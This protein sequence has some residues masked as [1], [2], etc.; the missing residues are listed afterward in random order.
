MRDPKITY[1]QYTTEQLT[2]S[3]EEHTASLRS[4]EKVHTEFGIVAMVHS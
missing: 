3:I 1:E 4:L 2:F